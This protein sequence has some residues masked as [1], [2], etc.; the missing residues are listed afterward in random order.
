M[1]YSVV[2][3]N[4][5]K[6]EIVILEIKLR[7]TVGLNQW[8]QLIGYNLVSNAKYGLL[9]NIN[10]GASERLKRILTFDVDNI[11]NSTKES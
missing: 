3:T 10:A 1:I 2:V 9:I 4:G 6:F 8:S 5:K 11:K 7:E